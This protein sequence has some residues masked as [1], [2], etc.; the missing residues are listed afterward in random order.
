MNIKNGCSYSDILKILNELKAPYTDYVNSDNRRE[1]STN[2]K[3]CTLN[4]SRGL[5]ANFVL[6]L[7]FEECQNWVE[8]TKKS[9][10]GLRA[11]TKNLGYITLSRAKK[12]SIILLDFTKIN[13]SCNFLIKTDAWIKDKLN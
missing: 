10:A 11:T 12:S 8:K 6:I 4:N 9:R 2:I 5:S 3:I 1:I 13:D 7:D